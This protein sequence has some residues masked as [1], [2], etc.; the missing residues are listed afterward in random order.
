MTVNERRSQWRTA[1]RITPA[2]RLS[3]GCE[4]EHLD[5]AWQYLMRSLKEPEATYSSIPTYGMF[6][7]NALSSCCSEDTSTHEY[8]QTMCFCKSL[9]SQISVY[10]AHY[11]LIYLIRILS[12]QY[13]VIILSSRSLILRPA[14]SPNIFVA[15]VFTFPSHIVCSNYP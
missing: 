14:A 15:A 5:L 8:T 9:T 6:I 1:A 7:L 2:L 10:G 3:K 12:K 11:M 4:I 13:N